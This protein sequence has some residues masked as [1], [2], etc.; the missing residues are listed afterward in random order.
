MVLNCFKLRIYNSIAV[1]I[2]PQAAA[3]L[4]KTSARNTVTLAKSVMQRW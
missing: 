1:L 4:A 3:I 2:R